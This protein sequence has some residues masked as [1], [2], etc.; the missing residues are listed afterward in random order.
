MALRKAFVGPLGDDIPSIFPIIAGVLL[1][2]STVYYVSGLVDARSSYLETR[3]SAL[4][5]SY[6]AT[7]KGFLKQEDF[8]DLCETRLKQTGSSLG[9]KFLAFLD[10]NKD[11]AHCSEISFSSS[12]ANFYGTAADENYGA[13]HRYGYCTNADPVPEAD[14]LESKQLIVLNYPIST[15]CFEGGTPSSI[16]GIGFLTVIA[17]K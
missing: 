11:F 2:L 6:I 16:R 3:K 1:F 8:E 10:V 13:M 4:D 17:W 15:P 12:P 14:E 7:E 9:V 5:L